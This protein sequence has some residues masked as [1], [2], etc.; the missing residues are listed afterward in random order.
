M[1]KERRSASMRHKVAT[2][3]LVFVSVLVPLVILEVL[4][5]L[6]VIGSDY[7]ARNEVL[8][9][10]SGGPLLLILGD[11]FVAPQ[12]GGDIGDYLFAEVSGARMRIRNTATSGTGPVDYLRR[13]RRERGR[14]RP[15]VLLLS[16]Y[17]GNDLLDTGC[18]ADIEARLDPPADPPAWQKLYTVQFLVERLRALMPGKVFIRTAAAANGHPLHAASIGLAASGAVSLLLRRQAVD[19]DAMRRAGIGEEHIAAARRGDVNPWIVNIGATNPDYYRHALAMESPCAL[20]AWSHQQR[21]LDLILEEAVAMNVRV[22]PVIFPHT[23]QVDT[24]HY[25]LYRSWKIHVDD[26]MSRG[27]RPQQLL[28]EYFRGR[29]LEP[30]DLLEAFRRERVPLFWERDE[31]LNMRGQQLAARLI[32]RSVMSSRDTGA[33]TA[34]VPRPL[35]VRARATRAA[36]VRPIALPYVVDFADSSARELLDGWYSAETAGGRTFAWSRGDRSAVRLGLRPMGD[37]RLTF[38]AMPLKLPRSPTQRV[39]VSVNGR[40]VTTQPLREG[41]HRYA[42]VLP[43]EAF[44]EPP[45]LVEFR[46]AYARAP[47]SSDAR[48]LAVAWYSLGFDTAR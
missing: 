22:L 37:V 43:A 4:L 6:N 27:S 10:D 33:V 9:E 29:G 1:P 31:H 25:S 36:P 8:G 34:N 38:E 46:Y 2:A 16:Y 28:T 26:E 19:Y 45:Q 15:D 14:V 21:V 44:G 39:S 17:V 7:H 41:L 12:D 48:R 40:E 3:A 30:L 42:I 35:P 47:R 24:A 18:D 32:A 23:F 13:L 11:S 20:R 5:R